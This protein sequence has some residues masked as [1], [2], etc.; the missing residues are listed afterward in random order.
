[1]KT[2]LGKYAVLPALFLSAALAGCSGDQAS[3]PGASAAAGEAV[4]MSGSFA[5]WRQLG[6][7]N[8]QVDNGEF[9]ATSGN[10]HL[11]TQESFS[12]FRITLDFFVD[13]GTANSGVY[14]RISNPDEIRDSNS[15]EANI[16]DERPDQSGRTGGLV[17]FAAPSE[18]ID[19]AGKWNTYDIT[20]QGD[21]IV[22][23]YNGVKTV[24]IRDS[25]YASG[26]ISLQYGAGEVRFRNVKIER[27]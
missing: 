19:A 15:Y 1:M 8:W 26:P 6:N 13:S 25:T 18:V 20:A 27:L 16:F 12:D 7:A 10:G 22:I 17:H 5:G 3:A 14:F 24:D 11:V 9:V 4:D 2:K 23:E 21:H